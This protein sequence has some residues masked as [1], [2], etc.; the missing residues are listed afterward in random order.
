MLTHC[1][2]NYIPIIA[3]YDNNDSNEI[4][5]LAKKVDKLGI[6]FSHNVNK[7]FNIKKLINNTSND[8]YNRVSFEKEGYKNIAQYIKGL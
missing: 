4:I 7:S 8:I 5:E 2:E 1:I 3:L 6:G